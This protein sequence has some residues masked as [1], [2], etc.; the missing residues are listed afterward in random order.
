[1]TKPTRFSTVRKYLDHRE[2]NLEMSSAIKLGTA[3]HG[4]HK[5]CSKASQKGVSENVWFKLQELLSDLRDNTDRVTVSSDLFTLVLLMHNR[6]M[7]ENIL[8][9]VETAFQ[10]TL[11]AAHHE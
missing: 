4:A 6:I 3:F 7:N 8:K 5:T 10:H 2:K 11:L 9:Y 1:M